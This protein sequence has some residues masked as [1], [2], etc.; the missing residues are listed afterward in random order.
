MYPQTLRSATGCCCKARLMYRP[1]IQFPPLLS[2]D[3]EDD[4][5]VDAAVCNFHIGKVEMSSSVEI[6]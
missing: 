3:S 6:V 2:S 1:Q 4:V 5:V